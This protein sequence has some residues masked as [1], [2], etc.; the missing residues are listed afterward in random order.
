[1]IRK[2]AND[3][4]SKKQSLHKS[5]ARAIIKKYKSHCHI[6]NIEERG[7]KRFC[8]RE[9]S[10]IILDMSTNIQG[11]LLGGGHCRCSVSA[12]TVLRVLKIA[13]LKARE[14]YHY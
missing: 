14:R 3:Q 1:M 9:Q 12:Q 8:R 4:I 7:K 2:K 5:T 10:E 11:S 6:K 13:G